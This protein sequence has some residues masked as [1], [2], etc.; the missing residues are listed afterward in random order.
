MTWCFH[1][2]THSEMIF[3]ADLIETLPTNSPFLCV[4]WKHWDLVLA[5]CKSAEHPCEG[6]AIRWTTLGF[7][8]GLSY[9]SS[10]PPPLPVHPS[11]HRSSEHSMSLDFLLFISTYTWDHAILS[12]V[13]VPAQCPMGPFMFSQM[14]GSSSLCGWVMLLCVSVHAH[15]H[16]ILFY[17]FIFQP[18]L[19]ASISCLSEVTALTGRAE[20]PSRD[21]FH[22]PWAYTQKWECWI[23]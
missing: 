13:S 8:T 21:W 17:P 18:T 14:E 4:W 3:T 22:F 6:A 7:H 10:Y 20:I 23:R 15:I 12:F 16:S 1:T 11:K 19:V 2:G 9:Q 5:D